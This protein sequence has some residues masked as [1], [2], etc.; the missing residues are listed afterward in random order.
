MKRILW[1]SQNILQKK[2]KIEMTK[3]RPYHPQSKIKKK[4]KKKTEA[5]LEISLGG[6]LR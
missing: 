5:W 6:I 3:S 2:R 1:W 4:K